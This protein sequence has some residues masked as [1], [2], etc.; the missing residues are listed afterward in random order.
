MVR[1]SESGG[2]SQ[3]QEVRVKKSGGQNQGVRVRRSCLR[4]KSGFRV[5]GSE[6]GGQGPFQEVM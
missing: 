1:M 6:S 4:G 3:S 5:M 2:Q